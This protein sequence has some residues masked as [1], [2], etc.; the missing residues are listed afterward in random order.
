MVTQPGRSLCPGRANSY[1]IIVEGNVVEMISRRP[2]TS[3]WKS[4]VR[5]DD[6]DFF[7]HANNTVYSDYVQSATLASWGEVVPGAHWALRHIEMTFKSPITFGDEIEAECLPSGGTD[8]RVRCAYRIRRS[9]DTEVAAESV[10]LWDLHDGEE[11]GAS[12]AA[13]WPMDPQTESFKLRAAPS[14]PNHPEA[15]VYRTQLRVQPYEVDHTGTVSPTWLFRWAW[16]SMF[17]ASA[18]AGW[19]AE[20]WRREGFLVF[21]NHRDADIFKSLHAGDEVEVESRLYDLHR[22]RG[23]WEHRILQRGEVVAID[24]ATGVFLN[25]EGKITPPPEGM[26]AEIIGGPG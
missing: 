13:D 9:R 25:L 7:G 1:T 22:V 10:A 20:R 6:C 24:R 17:S 4:T 11:S 19:S 21:Q 18:A 3:I 12:I 5:S 8:G 26:M 16:A 14:E 23:T 15:F 2:E